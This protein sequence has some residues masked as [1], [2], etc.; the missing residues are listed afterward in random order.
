[1]I[2]LSESFVLASIKNLGENGLLSSE[3]GAEEDLDASLASTEV[4]NH[5]IL[6]SR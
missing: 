4:S 1:M 5:H 2:G 3:D 6:P